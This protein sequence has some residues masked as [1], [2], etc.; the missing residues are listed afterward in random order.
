LEAVDYVNK[1]FGSNYG[2]F[3]KIKIWPINKKEAMRHLNHFLQQ[4]FSE[5][6][7]YEDAIV[8]N[9]PFLNHS[10]LSPV[11]NNGILTPKEVVDAIISY[12]EKMKFL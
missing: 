12:A 5:F 2:H 4:R 3:S 9:E 1:Y 8:S 6:G 7:I 10:L 11:I